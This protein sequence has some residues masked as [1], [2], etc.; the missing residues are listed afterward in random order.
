MDNVPN[1]Q[2]RQE[3]S[4]GLNGQSEPLSVLVGLPNVLSPT[5]QRCGSLVRKEVA[6]TQ[7]SG[8]N[9]SVGNSF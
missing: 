9:A 8:C 7:K 3:T 1:T 5:W 4:L 2:R 6:E